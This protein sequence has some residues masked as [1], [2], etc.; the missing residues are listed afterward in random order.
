M[1][2]NVKV[3]PRFYSKKNNGTKRSFLQH[4]QHIVF[5]TIFIAPQISLDKVSI[6]EKVVTGVH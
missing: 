3:Q 4:L 1:L 2:R 5:F 6:E